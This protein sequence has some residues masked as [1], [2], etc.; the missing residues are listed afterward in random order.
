MF[1]VQC[2]CGQTNDVTAERCAGCRALVTPTPASRARD[3]TYFARM[4][5][6]VGLL[7]LWIYSSSDPADHASMPGARIFDALVSLFGPWPLVL[8]W[9]IGGAAFLMHARRLKR[10]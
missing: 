7:W 3:D 4:F 6:V 5:F 1:V 8:P 2:R 10:A 9:W